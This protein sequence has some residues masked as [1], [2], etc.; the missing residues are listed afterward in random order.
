[1]GSVHLYGSLAGFFSTLFF[2]KDNPTAGFLAALATY[3]AGFLIRPFGAIVFGSLGDRVG[4]K[5]TFL[6]TIVIMGLSTA[7]V[8]VLP[9]FEQAG[10][11]SPILLVA[12]RL[13][14]GLAIGGEYGGAAIY[15]GEVSPAARRGYATSWIQTTSTGGLI[16]SLCVILLCRSALSADDFANWGW[17]VPF[18]ASVLILLFSLYIR[19]KLE[20]S[21]VFKAMLAQ[22]KIAQTPLRSALSSRANVKWI[23]VGIVMVCGASA[24]WALSQFYTLFYLTSTLKLDYAVTYRLIIVA[25]VIGAPAYILFGWLSDKIGRKPVMIVG[26]A[27]AAATTMPIF[28]GLSRAANPELYDF[29]KS[30]VLQVRGQ[31]STCDF[32]IF[33]KPVSLCDVIRDALNRNGLSY[34]F[35]ATEEAG[36]ALLIDGEA[37]HPRTNADVVSVLKSKGFPEKPDP[38]RVNKP[39][40]VALLVLLLLIVGAILGPMAAMLVELFPAAI[41]YTSVSVAY[42]IASTLFGGSLAFIVT[43]IQIYSGSVTSGFYFPI[44]SC[45]VAALIGLLVLPETR[46]RNIN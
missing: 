42:H 33:S 38:S 36:A 39:G 10:W 29:T 35:V 28:N 22:G 37:S 4:R 46:G 1:M 23:F 2:P 9:T 40:I 31:N 16:L 30:H 13:I 45:A 32:N 17:R 41:R 34:S 7:L 21:P 15:V 3:G 6:V 43:A 20:E 24:H 5:T 18:G 19:G 27:L 14:Q 26:L 25:L 44:A 12:L 8:A 11:L